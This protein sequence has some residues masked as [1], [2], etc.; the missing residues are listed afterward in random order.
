MKVVLAF[1]ASSPEINQSHSYQSDIL[2]LILG[3]GVLK[4]SPSSVRV[5]L[6]DLLTTMRIRHLKDN[7]TWDDVLRIN[8][9]ILTGDFSTTWIDRGKL[10][11]LLQRSEIACFLIEN[12]YPD[13]AK[14]LHEKLLLSSGAYLGMVD[15]RFDRPLQ[16]YFL[17]NGLVR[18][19]R[20]SSEHVANYFS[21]G[22]EEND[23]FTEDDTFLEFGYTVSHEDTGLRWTVFDKYYT[24]SKLAARV[25]LFEDL[26][27]TLPG[28]NLVD[29]SDLV[30][31]IDEL[32]P[33]LFDALHALVSA[34]ERAETVEQLSQACLSGR[35]F[36]QSLA[37]QLFPPRETKFNGRNVGPNEHKNRI[38]AYLGEAIGPGTDLQASLGTRF[39]SVYTFFN[40]AIHASR[41]QREVEAQC[42]ELLRVVADTVRVNPAAARD[43]YAAY[44]DEFMDQMRGELGLA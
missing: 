18:S 1:E 2:R 19:Y 40:S 3:T 42:A 36:L 9:E 17:A 26:A 25:A 22:D 29:A 15:V 16:W 4:R 44:S 41:D 28:V 24:D 6:G 35:R 38:W 14:E 10:Q 5:S 13:L 11:A 23:D 34:I 8:N 12:I 21:M 30:F 39:D 37:D 31:F 33:R 32:D 27:A 20:M 43:P 7:P